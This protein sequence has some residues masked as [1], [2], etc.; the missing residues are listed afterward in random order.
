MVS[1]IDEY[2]RVSGCCFTRIS[3]YKSL[4]FVSFA[5]KVTI[6]SFCGIIGRISGLKGDARI[7]LWPFVLKLVRNVNDDNMV[8]S[9]E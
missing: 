4:H 5:F 6:K 2:Y 8:I 7:I 3:D 9:A 1:G